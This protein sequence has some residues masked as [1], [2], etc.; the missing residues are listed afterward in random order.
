M[1]PGKAVAVGFVQL[2]EIL[3]PLY[4]GCCRSGER[5]F[6]QVLVAESPPAAVLAN[7][8]GLHGVDHQPAKAGRPCL[9]R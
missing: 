9:A 1:I 5:R 2:G 8:V 3:G 7:L 4:A 6:E